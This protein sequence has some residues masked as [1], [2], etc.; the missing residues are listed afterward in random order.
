MSRE[1]IHLFILHVSSDAATLIFIV[2]VVNTIIYFL[3][4]SAI[5]EIIVE[6]PDNA[7]FE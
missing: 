3:I 6:T 1:L 2:G 7:L 4:L 5:S